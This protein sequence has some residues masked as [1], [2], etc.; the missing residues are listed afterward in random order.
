MRRLLATLLLC[1]GVSA[2][3]F[4]LTVRATSPAANSENFAT[5]DTLRIWF[6]GIPGVGTQVSMQGTNAAYAVSSRIVRG[7]T[8]LITPRHFWLVGDQVT[9]SVFGAGVVPYTYD[10][11]ISV[12]HGSNYVNP[13]R[14]ELRYGFF[15]RSMVAVDVD[16]DGMTDLAIL[17]T[18]RLGVAHNSGIIPF[19]DASV[20]SWTDGG[21]IPCDAPRTLRAADLNGDGLPDLITSDPLRNIITVYPNQSHAGVIQFGSPIQF[22]LQLTGPSD[23]KIADVNSD[24]LPDIIAVGRTFDQ[25]TSRMIVLRNTGNFGFV[26]SQWNIGLDPSALDVAD[27]DGDGRLDVAVACRGDRSVEIMGNTSLNPL[28]FTRHVILDS[29]LAG[30]DGLIADN[31]SPCWDS[32]SD[33]QKPDLLV[34]S[35]GIHTSA[36]QRRVRTLD[37]QQYMLRY[38][39]LGNLT[40]SAGD[41]LPSGG[42]PLSVTAAAYDGLQDNPD[43]GWIVINQTAIGDTVVD[44]YDDQF[45]PL[46]EIDQVNSPAAALAADLDLDGD[47][48]FFFMDY[49]T[50]AVGDEGIVYLYSPQLVPHATLDFGTHPITGATDTATYAYADTG[51]YPLI[52]TSIDI[53][54]S[55]NAFRFLAPALPE[56]IQP[57]ASLTLTYGFTPP[58]SN[59]YGPRESRILFTG[60]PGGLGDTLYLVGVGGRSVIESVPPRG[61]ADTVHMKFGAFEAFG[62]DT[63]SFHLANTGNYPLDAAYNSASLNRFSLLATVDSVPPHSISGDSCRVRFVAPAAQGVYSELLRVYDSTFFRC[64]SFGPRNRLVRDTIIYSLEAR[65]IANHLPVF[66]FPDVSPFEGS[67]DTF[68]ITVS[69]PDNLPGEDSVRVMYYGIGDPNRS[70]STVPASFD[71][72]WIDST[73]GLI[74]HVDDDVPL[75]GEICHLAFRAWDFQ[76]PDRMTDTTW[77]IHI[78]AVDDPPVIQ[79]HDTTF[80]VN[81]GDSLVAAL[82]VSD[83]EHEALEVQ[84]T[85]LPSTARD[86]L[87]TA[88]GYYRIL[89][90]PGYTDSGT[91]PVQIILRE[92]PHPWLADTA[93]IIID[94]RDQLPDLEVSALDA[95]PTSIDRG[96]PVSIQY[97]IHERYNIPVPTPFTVTLT[98]PALGVDSVLST[99]EYPSLSAGGSISARFDDQLSVCGVHLFTVRIVPHGPDRD[100]SNDSRFAAVTVLCPDLAAGAIIVPENPHKHQQMS[101]QISVGEINGIAIDTP[102]TAVLEVQATGLTSRIAEFS[103]NSLAAHG[104]V[105]RSITWSPDTCNEHRFGFTVTAPPGWDANPANNSSSRIINVQCDPFVVYPLPFTPNGDGYNDTLKFDFGDERYGSPRVNIFSLDGRLVASLQSVE[106]QRFIYWMGKDRSG[107]DCPPGAYL[108]TLQDGDKKVASGIVYVAR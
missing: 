32:G 55:D 24:G 74:S 95:N 68:H 42:I 59:G 3:A 86:T 10:F 94:V 69:D 33:A 60:G 52:I 97:T 8:L 80:V 104:T 14:G 85:G 103:F 4:A 91:Y 96:G 36:I 1:T 83:E 46:G 56:T 71:T 66:H 34:W 98:D 90:R 48:D 35:R 62:T 11:S 25:T 21:H 43:K 20:L 70:L 76:F 19:F 72:T 31:V 39:N 100:A 82:R 78:N 5:R 101:L 12:P 67:T 13:W 61:D 6:D 108:Y 27:F 99:R 7:D 30:P 22:N 58:D 18:D 81:E 57:G 89:W 45:R 54:F 75:S 64:D 93:H 65:V 79:P 2:A 51:A 41:S 37:E 17:F 44:L 102:F 26:S 9:I 53:P 16:G 106:A 107:N 92:Q 73:F 38:C 50:A 28:S 88:A 63:E 77:V 23:F 47:L 29:L 84:V 105:T 15:P 40:F 87:D 49:E